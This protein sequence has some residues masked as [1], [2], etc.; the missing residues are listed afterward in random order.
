MC[1]SVCLV[2]PQGLCVVPEGSGSNPG[3]IKCERGT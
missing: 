2:K 3:G 1:V